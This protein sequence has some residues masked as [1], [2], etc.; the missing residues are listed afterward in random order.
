MVALVVFQN[1]LVN[2]AMGACIFTVKMNIK[3]VILGIDWKAEVSNISM[4]KIPK[5]KALEIINSKL[6]NLHEHCKR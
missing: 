2:L 6:E 1:M 3:N 5:G 4:K